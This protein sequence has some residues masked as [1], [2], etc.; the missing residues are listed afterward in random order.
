[1]AVLSTRQ[2]TFYL[3][4][5]S[6][7]FSCSCTIALVSWTLSIKMGHF[8]FAIFYVL[9]LHLH[10]GQKPLQIPF[11][12]SFSRLHTIQKSMHQPFLQ[13]FLL[14]LVTLFGWTGISFLLINHNL[15]HTVRVTRI[16]Q[17]KMTC[18]AFSC[19]VL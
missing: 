2:F 10:V 14:L 4:V 11:F 12:F 15:S 3:V 8:W 7:V 16:G 18:H 6:K 13:F 17:I 5:K 1:M 19:Y 9:L